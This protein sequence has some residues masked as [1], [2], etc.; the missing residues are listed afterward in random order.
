MVTE[1]YVSCN[2]FDTGG[3]TSNKYYYR[4]VGNRDSKIWS[5]V[6]NAMALGVA[7]LDSACILAEIGTTGVYPVTIFGDLPA[8][9]YDIIV[10]LQ[11]GSVPADTDNVEKQWTETKGDIF[12]F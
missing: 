6:A 2:L 1:D 9:T 4:I 11:A 5:Y 10:Y 12:G 7:W 8:G 3:H